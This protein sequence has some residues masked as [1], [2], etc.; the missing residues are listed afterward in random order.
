M[1]A[2]SK[3]VARAVFVTFLWSTSWVL[4]RF[5]LQSIPP[6][7]FAALRYGMA[8]LVLWLFIALRGRGSATLSLPARHWPKL[9]LLG[10]LYYTVTQAS[11]FIALSHLRA[12]TLS[13]LLSFS[14]VITA[15]IARIS[16]H[17]RMLVRQWAGVVLYVGATIV[18]LLPNIE[19]QWSLVG[20]AAAGV[21]VL[22]NAAAGVLG[23]SINRTKQLSSLTVTV[24]SMSV[25]S[26]VLIVAAAIT[27]GVPSLGVREWGILL[28][29]SVINTAFAF[30][31]WNQAHQELQAVQSSVIN[32]TMLYQIS[33]LAFIFLGERLLP[34][35][36]LMIAVGGLATLTVQLASAAPSRRFIP[37]RGDKPF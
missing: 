21:G 10:I 24:I 30:V 32:S 17:E 26:A 29:L 7:T 18:F 13:L 14:T 19:G 37:Q 12:T 8:T 31:M 34:L 20:Y 27:D 6:L 36:W 4:I 1:K 5:G 15:I 25:G 3:A 16:I 22:A 35:Q 28:W 23:R 9:I 2:H 33:L 11:Q